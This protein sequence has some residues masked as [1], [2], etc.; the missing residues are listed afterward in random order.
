MSENPYSA[1][2]APIGRDD[3]KEVPPQV[4][5]RIKTAWIAAAISGSI[6]LFVSLLA[7]G[8]TSIAGVTG[9]NLV[10]AALIFGLAYGIYRKSR[11]CA[12]IMLI[13]FIASK[14]FI[15]TQTHSGNGIFLAVVF[16][17]CF[18]QGVIGTFQYHKITSQVG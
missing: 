16:L 14:I 9:L 7:I 6:T 11:T 18:V 2:N 3:P 15:M 8:G 4:L 10:D 12:V 1:P 13:Y 17:L 5:S